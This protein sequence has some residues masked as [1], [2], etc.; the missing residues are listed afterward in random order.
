MKYKEIL[1]PAVF[2]QASKVKVELEKTFDEETCDT[3][4]DELN[5]YLSWIDSVLELLSEYSEVDGLGAP[6][7]TRFITELEHK[8]GILQFSVSWT[9]FV[10]ILKLARC[11]EGDGTLDLE[12]EISFDSNNYELLDCSELSERLSIDSFAHLNVQDANSSVG[13]IDGELN[14]DVIVG[15][16]D[17]GGFSSEFISLYIKLIDDE[18][19]VDKFLP[20]L[21]KHKSV[22]DLYST[23]SII[24]FLAVSRGFVVHKKINCGSVSIPSYISK[25]VTAAK[26]YHQFNET[27]TI[28]S[29]VNER[30]DVL[31][32]FLSVY[33]VLESFMFKVPIV[34]LGD[35][36]DYKL[37]SLREFQSLYSTTKVSE[38]EGL[39]RLFSK[40]EMGKF[41]NRNLDGVEFKRKIKDAIQG[42]DGDVDFIESEC[43]AIFSR[44]G[45]KKIASFTEIKKGSF[46][47]V[48]YATLFYKLRNSIVH[49][50]ETEVHVS[51]FNV[52]YSLASFIE[53]VFLQPVLL[54]IYDLI[55][56][57]AS[58]VWYK[59]PSFNLYEKTA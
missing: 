25:R 11:V 32:R 50:K 24:K 31:D 21:L 57:P 15:S 7:L 49:N 8:S 1:Y 26:P 41:W 45:Q 48:E 53:K 34:N 6:C 13:Y 12:E 5:E 44:F 58:K 51:Y 43:N 18:G 28:L 14:A 59:G 55:S 19:L 37:F 27:M 16:F 36:S 56:D 46:S 29:Q 42:L 35:E 39:V 22:G 30:V 2:N 52:K 23:F 33:H 10:Y 38:I 9:V 3:K 54:L 40:D 4:L 47:A 17:A 20:Y